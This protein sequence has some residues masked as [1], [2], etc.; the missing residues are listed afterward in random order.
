M[1]FAFFARMLSAAGKLLLVKEIVS[2]KYNDDV[3]PREAA[4]ILGIRL[5]SVY[6]L[7]W[8]GR[9]E[10]TKKDGKWSVSREAV[11][12]RRAVTKNT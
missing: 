1:D 8:A 4:K 10:A 7:V 9:L 12:A 6:S 5:E 2:M 3:S 11:N